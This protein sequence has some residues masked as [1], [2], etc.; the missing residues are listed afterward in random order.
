M[1]ARNVPGVRCVREDRMILAV[2]R[3]RVQSSNEQDV[4]AAFLKRS[5]EIEAVPGFLGMEPYIDSQDPSLFHV[6]T[7]WT[8]REAFQNWQCNRADSKSRELI[9]ESLKADNTSAMDLTLLE[10]IEHSE[11]S[12]GLEESALCEAPL[13]SRYL[14]KARY[15]IYAV[16]DSEGTVRSCDQAMA[17]QF[18]GDAVGSAIWTVLTDQSERDLRAAITCGERKIDE[19]LFLNFRGAGT[20]E[21]RVDVHPNEFVLIGEPVYHEQRKIHDQMFQLNTDLTVLTRNLA[22]RI[23]ILEGGLQEPLG[24]ISNYLAM[25]RARCAGDDESELLVQQVEII[26]AGMLGGARK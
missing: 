12:M 18:L 22:R 8:D 10:R 14:E 20:F 21:C 4:R 2:S 24:V 7:R 19:A 6:V 3:F 1:I 11:G 23:R 25:L 17:Q 9:P 5:R 16:A 13:I 15:V 26:L